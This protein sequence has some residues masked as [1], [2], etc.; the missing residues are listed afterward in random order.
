[1][2][3]KENIVIILSGGTGNRFDNV[4]PK[5]FAEAYG[6]SILDYCI[7]NFNKHQK[8]DKILLVS[9]PN[10]IDRAKQIANNSKYKKVLAVIEGGKTRGESSYLGLKY[11]KKNEKL[12]DANV[13]IHDAVR[14]NTNKNI[15]N[16]VI[17]KLKDSKAVSVVV[18]ATDTIYIADEEKNLVSIPPR[19]MI[20]QAQTPQ[21]FDFNTIYDA[22]ESL[23]RVSRF[24]FYDDCS[25]IKNAFP[26]L[27]IN[28]VIGDVS[29]LKITFSEDIETF[30][31]LLKKKN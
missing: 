1:M 23:Q 7:A 29:N 14:P 17:D 25:I 27:K 6:K 22:Y 30:R 13:L 31:Q 15:I 5:Q 10:Y 19:E 11:L 9:N 8:V 2:T 28:L 26:Q 18:P 4:L 20:F 16:D 12:S 24:K 21:G 3:Y